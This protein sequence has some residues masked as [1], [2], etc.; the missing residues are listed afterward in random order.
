MIHSFQRFGKGFL[1]QSGRRVPTMKKKSVN[2]Y[3]LTFVG[4]MAAM[5][6]VVTLFRFPLLG[7]KVHFANAVCLLSGMLL[8]PWWGGLAAGLGSA[9]YDALA[10]G[11]DFINVLITFVSKFA[12]AF[13]CGALMRRRDQEENLVRV[14]LASVCGALTY[15][16]LYMLK[17]FIYQRFVYGYPMDAVGATMV[18]KLVP[19]LIN[20]AV[21]VVAAPVFYHALRP[22]LRSAGVW[23]KLR[24]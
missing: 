3:V 17:T 1:P 4:V 22:A 10:G 6:Y 12:M 13:V 23:E 2:A 7:S 5:V 11:Y 21:A 16:V 24:G 19:S 15:V 8:G 20:A 9:L 18:A 14:I